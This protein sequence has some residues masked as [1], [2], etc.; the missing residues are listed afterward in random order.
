MWVY[1]RW[2]A[3]LARLACLAGQGGQGGHIVRGTSVYIHTDKPGKAGKAGE[4]SKAGKAQRTPPLGMSP[5]GTKE[6]SA[7]SNTPM[8]AA[9]RSMVRVVP[10]P[11]GA[12]PSA[13]LRALWVVGAAGTGVGA[14]GA[15][16][17]T[18]F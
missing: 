13:T 3:R 2:I 12:W 6:S 4:A 14:L 8:A 9:M 1:I 15:G 17:A 7:P 10:T 5:A 18:F 11:M 16:P